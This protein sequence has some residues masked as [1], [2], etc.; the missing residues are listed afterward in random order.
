[1]REL[2]RVEGDPSAEIELI[3]V[4]AT[5]SILIHTRNSEYRFS[6]IDP[7]QRRGI[8]SGGTFG[9]DLHDATLIGALIPGSDLGDSDT[10]WLRTNA[11]ALFYVRAES[12]IRRFTTS[13]ITKLIH[14]K[15][16]SFN[17]QH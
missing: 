7:E 6:I 5:D 17:E 8:L 16:E 12:G 2:T 1:M 13:L 14:I 15:S 3:Q 10:S 11:R 9:D 4:G